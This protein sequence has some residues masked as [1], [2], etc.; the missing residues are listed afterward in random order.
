MEIWTRKGNRPWTKWADAGCA[1]EAVAEGA[2]WM[3]VVSDDPA[4]GPAAAA[5][6]RLAHRMA[7]SAITVSA[8][9]AQPSAMWVDAVRRAGVDSASLV[10]EALARAWRRA[11]VAR[12]DPEIRDGLC[13]SLL[14][15]KKQGRVVCL[16]GRQP[17]DVMLARRHLVR[18][19][20]GRGKACPWARGAACG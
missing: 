19:C 2:G 15:R 14:S 18:W 8:A 6:I 3:A 9:S 5:T 13:P 11:P 1:L 12:G 16:C 17:V 10:P 20:L 7:P 4:E